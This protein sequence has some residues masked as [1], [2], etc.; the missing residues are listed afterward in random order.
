MENDLSDRTKL[1]NKGN[2]DEIKKVQNII[3]KLKTCPK[4]KKEDYSKRLLFFSFMILIFIIYSIN[5]LTH[6][7]TKIPL[8]SFASSYKD[9]L[10][11]TEEIIAKLK[12]SPTYKGP[13]FP[14]DGKITKEWIFELIE[15]MKDLDYKKSY[16]EKYIDK[17]Y[18]LKMISKAKSILG[19]NDESIVDINIPKDKNFT[20]VGDIHGQ[21]YDLLN[22]FEI[23]GYP[24]EDNIYLF[25][26]DM[27]DRGQFG[28]EVITTL[29]AFKILYPNHLFLNRGNHEDVEM[30]KRYGFQLEVVLDKYDADVFDCFCEFYKFLPLGYVLSNKIL[31]IHG[32]LF[33]REGV[34]I[35]ELKKIDRYIDV[36][37]D[38]NSMCEL[39]WSDPR[40]IK[41][42]TPSDRGAGVYFGKDVTEKFL[43][44][45]NLNLLIRSHEVKMEGYDI[46]HDGKVITL[47]SAP[48]YYDFEGNKAA[49]IKFDTRLEPIFIQFDAVP[50]P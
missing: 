30:N 50:H 7:N 6:K 13:V 20:V 19:E 47:F 18:L 46:Q 37:Y 22:L 34:T 23:N 16:E 32:G 49:I 2:A 12:P 41:G 14:D 27:I 38:N 9:K 3:D 1:N 48:N 31:V 11:K 36:Q 21:F 29:I 43:S 25:N 17:I 24:S 42:W 33:S 45:N 40:D 28:I 10:N 5:V 44:E 39:L 26:G 15:F 35:S 8:K 4:I